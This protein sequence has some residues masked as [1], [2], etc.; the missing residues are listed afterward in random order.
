MDWGFCMSLIERVAAGAGSVA[1]R[2]RTSG[3]SY[4][5]ADAMGRFDR[6]DD[7]GDLSRCHLWKKRQ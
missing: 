4:R 6:I 1:V 5:N 2:H 7:V 3:G